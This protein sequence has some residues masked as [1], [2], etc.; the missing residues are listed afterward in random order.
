MLPLA[1]LECLPGQQVRKMCRGTHMNVSAGSQHMKTIHIPKSMMSAPF[2]QHP[3]LTA[4][5]RRYLCSIA[6]VYSTEH[7]RRQ[8]KQH[9]LNVLHTC[10]QSG[11]YLNVSN[12]NFDLHYLSHIVFCLPGQNPACRR[13]Y[14]DHQQ[15][16]NRMFTKDAGKAVEARAKPQGQRKGSSTAT[17]DVILPKIVN[18]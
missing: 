15:R 14:G 6:N 7:M 16:E 8:M 4:G 10:V 5:Q 13:R 1:G 18:R 12:I 9:Y 2:L 17:S 11:V 3:A